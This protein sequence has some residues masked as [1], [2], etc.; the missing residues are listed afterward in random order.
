MVKV[1]SVQHFILNGH[2]LGYAAWLKEMGPPT[3]FQTVAWGHV[4]KAIGNGISMLHEKSMYTSKE[5]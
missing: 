3:Y 4:I 1:V 2:H 5:N